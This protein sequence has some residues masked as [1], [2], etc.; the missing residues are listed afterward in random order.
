MNMNIAILCTK[1]L[2]SYTSYCCH[3]TILCVVVFTGLHFKSD[4]LLGKKMN[5]S[6]ELSL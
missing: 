5:C 4:V 6:T 1:H 2:Y 3:A